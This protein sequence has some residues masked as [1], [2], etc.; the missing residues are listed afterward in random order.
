MARV[1]KRK[2][3]RKAIHLRDSNPLFDRSLAL[4]DISEMKESYSPRSKKNRKLKTISRELNT[5]LEEASTVKDVIE[6]PVVLKPSKRKPK[7]YEATFDHDLKGKEHFSL[8][9]HSTSSQPSL[10]TPTDV[11]PVSSRADKNE[12]GEEGESEEFED[13]YYESNSDMNSTVIRNHSSETNA[14]GDISMEAQRE[15]LIEPNSSQTVEDILSLFG[16][17]S[18]EKYFAERKIKPQTPVASAKIEDVIAVP[19]PSKESL[20]LHERKPLW[21]AEDFEED[22]I[23]PIVDSDEIQVLCGFKD[24]NKCCHETEMLLNSKDLRRIEGAGYDRKE[25]CLKQSEADGLWQLKNVDGKCY[26]LSKT[27]KCTIYDIRPEGCRL[28]PFV[29]VLETDEI[30]ID[31][32]C[33]ESDWFWEQDYKR[34]QEKAIRG[35]VSTI[36]L[37]QEDSLF[38]TKNISIT[39]KH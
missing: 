38:D 11:N 14:L 30:V 13:K 21:L 2:K 12:Q 15:D 37:E 39:K 34:E 1:K 9:D 29:M 5:E 17:P 10:K 8:Q 20:N 35:L 36:I 25:F 6:Q 18:E 19:P 28:Y 26:F 33:R 7:V 3:R 16:A 23:F 27:G 24:C 22:F 4:P 31:S 32:D